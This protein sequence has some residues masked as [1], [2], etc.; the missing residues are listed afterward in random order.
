MGIFKKLIDLLVA[1]LKLGFTYG[2]EYFPRDIQKKFDPPVKKPQEFKPK[3]QGTG[4][5]SIRDMTE[6][7]ESRWRQK[8]MSE[9]HDFSEYAEVNEFT[10]KQ[11]KI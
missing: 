4:Y 10:L 7:E 2:L 8:Y 1:L 5:I 11:K 6:I 3:K 9:V